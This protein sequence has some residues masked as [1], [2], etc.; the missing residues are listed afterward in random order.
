[1]INSGGLSKDIEKLLTEQITPTCIIGKIKFELSEQDASALDT[2]INSKVT[3]LQICN[4]LRKHNFKVGNTA[5]AVH[6]K[7]QCLCYRS[8]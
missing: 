6:R 3:V 8:L 2:L 4:I 5:V 7:K 1:M